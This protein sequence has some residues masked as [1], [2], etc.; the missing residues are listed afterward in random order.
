MPHLLI[1]DEPTNHLD[2]E[3]RELLLSLNRLFSAVIL[4]SMT[5]IFYH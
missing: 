5:C 3:S 1:L 2:I 4:V